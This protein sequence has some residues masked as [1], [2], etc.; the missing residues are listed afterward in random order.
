M[1]NFATKYLERFVFYS[2]LMSQIFNSLIQLLIPITHYKIVCAINDLIC[3]CQL[4][5]NLL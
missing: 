5:D 3:L 4:Y 1:E 2:S